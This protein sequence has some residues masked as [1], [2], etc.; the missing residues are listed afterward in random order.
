M[1][2]LIFL[3]IGLLLVYVAYFA[4]PKDKRSKVIEF[5][6]RHAVGIGIILLIVLACAFA[7]YQLP[8]SSMTH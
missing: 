8:V 3:F 4:T 5:V 2:G 7:A 6:T 1:R